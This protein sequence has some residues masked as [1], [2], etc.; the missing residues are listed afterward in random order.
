MLNF[1]L[2][3]EQEKIKLAAREFALKEVLPLRWY[4]VSSLNLHSRR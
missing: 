2:S 3:A 4:Y 1:L